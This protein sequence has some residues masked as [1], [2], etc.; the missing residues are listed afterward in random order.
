MA[1]FLQ[2]LGV[3][4]QA[5]KTGATEV[6]NHGVVLADWIRNPW[7]PGQAPDQVRDDRFLGPRHFCIYKHFLIYT[8]NVSTIIGM[9][10]RYTWKE[11]KRVQNLAKHQLDFADAGLVLD[12]PYRLEYDFDGS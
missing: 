11:V 4:S 10:M 3:P 9:S 5:L 7:I 1:V 12:N 2:D 6:A 8:I